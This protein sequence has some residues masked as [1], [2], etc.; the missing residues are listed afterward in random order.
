MFEMK[1]MLAMLSLLVIVLFVV[2]CAPKEGA[3]AVAGQAV[4]SS[5][6]DRGKQC[7]FITE[8]PSVK[9]KIICDSINAATEI[10]T[11]KMVLGTKICSDAGY[12]TCAAVYRMYSETY[13]ASTNKSCVGVQSS[14][15]DMVYW[16]C[17]Q[18]IEE[19]KNYACI[20]GTG[21]DEAEPFLGDRKTSSLIYKATCCKFVSE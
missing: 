9:G 5:Y 10:D 4:A 7:G 8:V 17:T 16:P 1:K 20:T 19:I 21:L 13:F 11:T 12:D 14:Y 18:E 3:E 15:A 6:C 2:S